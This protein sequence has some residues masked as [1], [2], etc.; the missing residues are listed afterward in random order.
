[1]NYIWQTFWNIEFIKEIK[2]RFLTLL[3]LMGVGNAPMVEPLK[4]SN[5]FQTVQ[6]ISLILGS[7]VSITIIVRFV[8]FI[9]DKYFKGGKK[10]E[11]KS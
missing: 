5:V 3:G 11:F 9:I 4:S 10:D 8:I 6:L 1:M 2:I 7:L